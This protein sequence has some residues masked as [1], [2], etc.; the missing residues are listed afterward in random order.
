[1]LALLFSL[2]YY[3]YGS[4]VYR[5]CLNLLANGSFSKLVTLERPHEDLWWEHFILF[6]QCLMDCSQ[7]CFSRNLSNLTVSSFPPPFCREC[8]RWAAWP[9]LLWPVWAGAPQTAGHA[10]PAVLRA[11]LPHL[12][13]LGREHRGRGAAQRQRRPDAA[14]QP[15]RHRLQRPGRSSDGRRPQ[16]QTHQNGEKCKHIVQVTHGTSV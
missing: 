4:S 3:D 8:P 15:E 10:P 13:P 14:A 11:L 16:T 2:I 1:M 5:S 9:L 12:H 7:C 6:T